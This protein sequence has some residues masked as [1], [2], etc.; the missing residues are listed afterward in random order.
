MFGWEYVTVDGTDLEQMLP[1]LNEL[2]Q[3]GWEV[4]GVVAVARGGF[5]DTGYVQALLKREI[6]DSPA[7]G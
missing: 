3:E 1:R 4:V 7:G 5:G 6:G 2:G